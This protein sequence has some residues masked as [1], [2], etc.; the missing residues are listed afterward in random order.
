MDAAIRFDAP[1][2]NEPLSGERAAGARPLLRVRNAVRD[3]QVGA[4][5]YTF[6]VSDASDFKTILAGGSVSEGAGGYAGI[7]EWRV[8][9]DLG[10]KTYYWRAKAVASGGSGPYMTTASFRPWLDEIDPSKVTYTHGP[11]IANW[12]ITRTL[13]KVTQGEVSAGDRLHLL[14]ATGQRRLAAGRLLR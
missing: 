6:E 14:H 10:D 9:T 1:V 5:T 13:T 4:V 8:T 7:T 11:S 2:I 12:P 3:S